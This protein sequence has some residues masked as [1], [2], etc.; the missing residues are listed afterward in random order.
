MSMYKRRAV[1]LDRD[2]T[3]VKIVERPGHP[4]ER[5]SPFTEDELEFFPDT[6]RTLTE[7]K[8][9]G[10]LRIMITN[11]PDVGYGYVSET[12]W[13]KIHRRIVD[14]LGLDDVFMCRHISEDNCPFRKPSGL[15]L[16]AAADKW[17]IDMRQS[18]MIGDT[19]KDMDAGRAAKCK[20]VIM[21]NR[22]YN[23]HDDSDVRADTLNEVI[24]IILNDNTVK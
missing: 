19:W 7:F 23:L 16:L 3:L 10:Y 14:T 4:K 21:L 13:Q 20:R 2:G 12:D 22:R 6:Y 17:G 11:Q 5:T 9:M 18:Y 1:F 8:K 15:M 24:G